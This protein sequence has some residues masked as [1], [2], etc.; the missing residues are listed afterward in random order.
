MWSGDY[1]GG[2]PHYGSKPSLLT[3]LVPWQTLRCNAAALA[4][5]VAAF[6]IKEAY[7]QLIRNVFFVKCVSSYTGALSAFAG[8]ADETV[9]LLIARSASG[10]VALASVGWGVLNLALNGGNYQLCED[11]Y[12]K[13]APYCRRAE[14]VPVV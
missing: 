9:Q 4:V 2:W 12:L 6:Y 13:I 10:T 3:A 5:V 7:P 1:I 8:T 14:N 11:C